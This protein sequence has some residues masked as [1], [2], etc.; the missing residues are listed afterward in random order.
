MSRDWPLITGLYRTDEVQGFVFGMEQRAYVFDPGPGKSQCA[1]YILEDQEAL[2]N[3]QPLCLGV[4]YHG[5]GIIDVPYWPSL[6][7]KNRRPIA[8]VAIVDADVPREGPPKDAIYKTQWKYWLPPQIFTRELYPAKQT[9]TDCGQ[10]SGVEQ[11]REKI[12]DLANLRA[13]AAHPDA[14]IEQK[15]AFLMARSGV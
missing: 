7:P 10:Y 8:M 11:E 4:M 15:M 5:A 2:T 9:G 14:T 12:A 3:P 13:Q 6:I 1:V